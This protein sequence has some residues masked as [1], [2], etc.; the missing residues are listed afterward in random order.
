MFGQKRICAKCDD[1]YTLTKTKPG[2]INVCRQC[3]EE[4]EKSRGNS[5]PGGIMEYAHKTAPT[6]RILSLN[7]AK[8]IIKNTDRVGGQGIIKGM[9]ERR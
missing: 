7:D 4:Q 5:R 6:I 3:G 9:A 8:Q 2:T 1:E